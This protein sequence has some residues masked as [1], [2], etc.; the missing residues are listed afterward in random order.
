MIILNI[1]ID[2][3]SVTEPQCVRKIMIASRAFLCILLTGEVFMSNKPPAYSF[4]TSSFV[5]WNL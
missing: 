1:I 5:Y 3:E 2:F 4:L